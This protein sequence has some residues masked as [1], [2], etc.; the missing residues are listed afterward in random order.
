L[1]CT[2]THDACD[3]QVGVKAYKSRAP[4]FGDKAQY[5]NVADALANRRGQL[6]KI[7]G[8]SF[9]PDSSFTMDKRGAVSLIRTKQL[10]DE[11]SNVVAKV[12]CESVKSR[13]RVSAWHLLINLKAKIPGTQQNAPIPGPQIPQVTTGAHSAPIHTTGATPSTTAH[14]DPTP[15]AVGQHAAK[16]INKT[17]PV[18]EADNTRIYP[19]PVQCPT[20]DGARNAPQDKVSPLLPK[21]APVVLPNETS[22]EHNTTDLV[23]KITGGERSTSKVDNPSAKRQLEIGVIN[24]KTTEKNDGGS[25]GGDGSTLDKLKRKKEALVEEIKELEAFK[26]LRQKKAKLMEDLAM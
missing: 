4:R 1:H 20:N 14:R 5:E 12:S 17:K 2:A 13:R 16:K 10:T 22:T 15:T 19:T 24:G 3:L 25:S 9:G 21:T 26:A 7:L 11:S 6:E 23:P 8:V 18:T